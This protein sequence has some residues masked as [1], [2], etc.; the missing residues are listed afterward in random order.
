MIGEYLQAMADDL[1]YG[2]AADYPDLTVRIMSDRISTASRPLVVLRCE[3]VRWARQGESV[4]DFQAI[5]LWDQYSTDS[6]A[7]PVE[8]IA[9]SF[10]ELPPLRVDGS[11]PTTGGIDLAYRMHSRLAHTLHHNAHDAQ[12]TQGVFDEGYGYIDYV[13]SWSSILEP[14]LRWGRPDPQGVYLE[15]TVEVDLRRSG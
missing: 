13:V 4:A 6:G 10:V 12:L 9:E 5:L 14:D 1:L 2:L 11:L 15:D 8:P 7:G 3:N